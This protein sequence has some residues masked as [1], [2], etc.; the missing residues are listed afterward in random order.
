M[1]FCSVFV[2]ELTVLLTLVRDRYSSVAGGAR[3][4]DERVSQFVCLRVSLSAGVSFRTT[5]LI[6]KFFVHVTYGRDSV[7]LR[8]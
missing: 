4:C 6:T 3:Y 8:R 1:L 2:F 7:F 5:S